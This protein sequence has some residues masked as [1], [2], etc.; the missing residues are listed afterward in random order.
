MT[1]PFVLKGLPY[2]DYA[3]IMII[4]AVSIYS[5]HTGTRIRADRQGGV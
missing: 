2:P 3:R 1:T 5:T 4:T